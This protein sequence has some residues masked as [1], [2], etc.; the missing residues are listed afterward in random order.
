MARYNKNNIIYNKTNLYI[1]TTLILQY[2]AV[3]GLEFPA[4]VYMKR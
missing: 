1:I 4:G 3:R 2:P